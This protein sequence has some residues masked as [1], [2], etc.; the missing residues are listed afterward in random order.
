MISELIVTWQ[1]PITHSWV[2][3]GQLQ[4]KNNKYYFK[5]TI[6]AKKESNFIPFGQMNNLDDSYE[7]EELFPLF[8]NRLLP[9]SRPEY[10]DYLNWLNLDE[11]TIDPLEELARTTGIKATDSLQLFMIPEK[12]NEMYNVTFFSHGIRHLTP[13]YIE[14]VGH[15]SYGNK[16][17][18]MKDIQNKFDPYALVLRTDDPAE[19][20][21]YCPRFFVCDFGELIKKNGADKVDVSVIK[22]NLNSPLQFR[23][24][25]QFSTAW[26][27]DFVPFKDEAFQTIV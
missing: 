2:P 17:Y 3:V 13:H 14:R 8:K 18:L 10:N 7:S 25:C 4:Y 1:N 5:Y 19:I 21:G 9:K 22:V 23:L 24:L 11:D 16:L 20:V 15:L 6:G 12:T 27:A 26:P